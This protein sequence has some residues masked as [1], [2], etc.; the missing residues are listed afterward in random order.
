MK[1][2]DTNILVRYYA[3]DDALQSPLALRLFRNEPQLFVTK[4]VLLEFFWV[5]TRADRFCFPPE[6]VMA[7]FEHL[8]G[9]PNIVM[10]M[11]FRSK[12]PSHWVVAPY[13]APRA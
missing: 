8:Q 5:L 12:Q 7:V 9:L 13:K 3:Q 4:T 2:V 1:S 6:K 10:K 11:S